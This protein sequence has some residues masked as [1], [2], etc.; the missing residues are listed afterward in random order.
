MQI[1]R[2]RHDIRGMCFDIGALLAPALDF[3][4]GALDD[5]L[6]GAASAG[7]GA[8]TPF[9]GLGS[10]LGNALGAGGFGS[11]IN[12]PGGTSGGFNPLQALQGLFSGGGGAAA[13]APQVYQQNPTITQTAGGANSPFTTNV[14]ISQITGRGGDA[15]AS[16]G[17]PFSVSVAKGGNSGSNYANV[18]VDPT[19][20][21]SSNLPALGALP[22]APNLLQGGAQQNAMTPFHPIPMPAP[23][24][25][26]GMTM[27]SPQPIAAG[28]VSPTIAAMLASP[29]QQQPMSGVQ[30]I[31]PGSA[32]WA[33]GYDS[34]PQQPPM[35]QAGGMPQMQMPQQKQALSPA[36]MFGAA[37]PMAMQLAPGPQQGEVS[38]GSP[39]PGLR[40]YTPPAPQGLSATAGSLG[41]PSPT[42]LQR[43]LQG[44][45]GQTTKPDSMLDQ[46]RQQIAKELEDMAS[47]PMEL[48]SD[49]LKQYQKRLEDA[50]KADDIATAEPEARHGKGEKATDDA[51]ADAKSYAD[52][53]K[54]ADKL[55][56]TRQKNIDSL[57][58][59]LS[60]AMKALYNQGA[61][62]A[63]SGKFSKLLSVVH[64]IAKAGVAGYGPYT[65]GAIAQDNEHIKSQKAAATAVYNKI[66]EEG[67]KMLTHQLDQAKEAATIANSQTTQ[68]GADLSRA[69]TRY[70]EERNQADKET[71][72]VA[73]AGGTA[74]SHTANILDHLSGIMHQAST[75]QQSAIENELANQRIKISQQNAAS[76]A[77]RAGVAQRGEARAE[78]DEP[79]LLAGRD[80]EIKYKQK[81][82]GG[83]GQGAILQES[84]RL[85]SIK[86]MRIY[87]RLSNLGLTKA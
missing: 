75:E 9:S 53:E 34:P 77:L 4:G 40:P 69:Q 64:A 45:T 32:S 35:P 83:P 67:D 63:N 42:R 57:V 79:S 8:L 14:D 28:G 33:G 15:T 71:M 66:Q 25:P 61:G 23:N 52:P 43:P 82:T 68:S 86:L 12:L 70:N 1:P 54:G 46:T 47:K 65:A 48:T 11:A 78:R 55:G 29:Q 62:I 30:P 10:D 72:G 41:S 51:L 44:G 80:A 17:G 36:S 73:A 26:M 50:Q 20:N 22:N 38:Q 21:L 76:N 24:S 6:G 13:A 85:A 87:W 37:S 49:A 27:M 18:S 39:M 58:S 84:Q 56:D 2:T 59:H 16:G 31:I 81:L 3:T 5:L 74:I 7:A 19:Y 60:P